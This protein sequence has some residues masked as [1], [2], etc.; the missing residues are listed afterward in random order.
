VSGPR[1][2]V[3]GA[4]AFGGWTALSL[5]R[6]GAQVTLIDAW[7]PGNSRASSGGETR[8]IRGVY[9][10]EE[11][12]TRMAARSLVLWREAE[13]RWGRPLYRRTGA[14]WMVADEGKYVRSSMPHL[15]ENGLAFEELTTGEAARRYPQIAFDGI[16]WALFEPEAGFLAAR[17][18]CA[19]VVEGFAAEGGEYRQAAVA[20]PQV[21]RGALEEIRLSDGSSLSADFFVFACG[22]WLPK[23]F[24]DVLGN[25]VTPIRQEVFFFGAPAGDD[26]FSD[27]RLPVWLEVPR[28]F[29]GIPGYERRGFKIADD[30]R[31]EPFDPTDGDRR[32][33]A[34]AIDAARRYIAHRFPA[35]GDAPLLE[36]RVCQYEDTPDRHF[37]LDRHPE[38]SN[39]WIVGGGSGHGFKHGPAMGELVADAVLGTK[40]P[41]PLFSLSR[42]G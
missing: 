20:A 1:T 36:S 41:E 22:P 33:T 21:R 39:V 10:G 38:A 11:I 8:V 2:I 42:F 18:A 4:G 30:A 15:S 12:Y 25:L 14:L 35:L 5:R 6:R 13:A 27:T 28:F 31:G 3:V 29:Y 40:P 17:R 24:P 32:P 19:D 16:R 26:R 9:G 37:L 7:G 23:L 34:T